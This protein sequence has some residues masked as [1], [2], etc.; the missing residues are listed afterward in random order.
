MHEEIRNQLEEYLEGPA[1]RPSLERVRRHLEGCESCRQEAEQMLQQAELLRS[2]RADEE[3]APL[4]GF[5]ARVLTRVEAQ[6][7]P[8]VLAAFLDPGFGRRLVFASLA[9]ALGFGSYLVYAERK[10]VL[11]L[12]G[13]VNFIAAQVSPGDQVGG[14][15][16]RDRQTMLLA[17]ASYQE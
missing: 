12:A 14:D 11:E 7:R 5:Y 1:N 17:V 3:L 13:A 9:A 10:P 16:E 2:L 6:R 8:S 4:P 15:P